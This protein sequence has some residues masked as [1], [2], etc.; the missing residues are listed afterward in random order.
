MPLTATANLKRK[1]TMAA[2]V[3]GLLGHAHLPGHG[4]AHH[5][6]KASLTDRDNAHAESQRP[7]KDTQHSHGA[8]HHDSSNSSS[9]PPPAAHDQE[10]KRISELHDKTQPMSPE[11]VHMDPENKHVGHST[12]NLSLDDFELITTLGT[13]MRGLFALCGAGADGC[14]A[15]LRV[16][17]L[18][19]SK[20]RPVTTAR[21]CMR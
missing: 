5:D 4:H 17:G 11:D 9:A 19:A 2:A 14:Q 3:K 16:C 12:R 8:A 20:M 21:R 13:G 7:S 18:R 1:S 15:P 10:R 6:K